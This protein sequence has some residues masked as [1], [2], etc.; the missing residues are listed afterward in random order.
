MTVHVHVR[1][2]DID[3]SSLSRLPHIPKDA[4]FKQSRVYDLTKSSIRQ[5]TGTMLIHASRGFHRSGMVPT[6]QFVSDEEPALRKRRYSV[7]AIVDRWNKTKPF[8]LRDG[9]EDLDL[10]DTLA[11]VLSP[12]H[13]EIEEMD[14]P[15]ARP[16]VESLPTPSRFWKLSRPL[17]F[18][19]WN[20]TINY[21]ELGNSSLSNEDYR[22]IIMYNNAE[23]WWRDNV[24][25]VALELLSQRYMCKENLIEITNSFI[26]Q[27]MYQVGRDGDVDDND[28]ANYKDE[29]ERFANKKWIFLP[30]NDG[31]ADYGVYGGTHWS[32]LVVNRI[33]GI[34]HYVDSLFI[35]KRKQHWI[36]HRV[37]RGLSSIIGQDLTLKLEWASPNQIDNNMFS[38]DNGAC[39]PFVYFMV[40]HF[41]KIIRDGQNAGLENLLDLSMDNDY[42]NR[43]G[44]LFNSWNV[45][46]AVAMAIANEKRKED[47]KPV[48]ARHNASIMAG[49]QN[50]VLI[51][52]IQHFD[53]ES[54]QTEFEGDTAGEEQ[55][56][57]HVAETE[58]RDFTHTTDQRTIAET[59]SGS[60]DGEG[61]KDYDMDSDSE[62]PERMDIDDDLDCLDDIDVDIVEDDLPPGNHL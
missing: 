12:L 29:K 14:V 28:F 44:G 25:N 30:I 18:P 11:P 38:N 59:E 16:S 36:A 58:E 27:L 5:H 46:C 50:T 19:S 8:K 23:S 52:G 17:Y 26:T 31:I 24:L 10:P 48:A 9:D 41:T 51:E 3:L 61:F 7:D 35:H 6:Q 21:L 49:L 43:I 22:T 39:G 40:K 55:V 37:T 62:Q 15:I 20:D 32:F 34:A 53:Q 13:T 57:E 4:H 60:D 33:G 42:P 1:V 2:R 56:E 45:R 47:A 54:S